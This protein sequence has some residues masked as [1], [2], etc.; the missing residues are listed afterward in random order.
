MSLGQA[1]WSWAVHSDSVVLVWRILILIA[2][3]ANSSSVQFWVLTFGSNDARDS[4]PGEQVMEILLP[5]S[6]P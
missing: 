2:E 6:V 1:N 3:F 4:L 5:F